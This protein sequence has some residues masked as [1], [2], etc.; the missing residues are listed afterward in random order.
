M[1]WHTL[2]QNIGVFVENVIK[3]LYVR[4]RE[5]AQWLRVCTTLPKDLSSVPGVYIRQLNCLSDPIPLAPGGTC[6]YSHAS[7]QIHV[8]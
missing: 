8:I 1:I 2:E 6:T 7:T 3:S 5:M 4:A